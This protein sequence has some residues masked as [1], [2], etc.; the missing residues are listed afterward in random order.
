VRRPLLLLDACVAINVI[1]TNEFDS[2]AQCLD[3]QFWMARQA[4]AEVGQLRNDVNGEI[5]PIPIDL[6]AHVA[7]GT[8]VVI[9]LSPFELALYV[10]LAMVVDDGE[11]ASIAVAL[12]RQIGMATD[13]RK[14]RRI[15]AERGLSEPVRTADL[16][17]SYCESLSLS[18]EQV[19]ERLRRIRDR[20]SFLPPRTDPNYKWWSDHIEM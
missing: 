13:D 6:Q 18:A 2:I 16:M 20:A 10:E 15:C 8:M 5:V 7:A 4:A 1:A 12:S 3:I 17:K 9:E 11:A 14:A 19:G